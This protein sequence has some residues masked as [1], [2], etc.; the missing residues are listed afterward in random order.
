MRGLWTTTMLL[1]G[2]VAKII[3]VV[4]ARDSVFGTDLGSRHLQQDELGGNLK[5]RVPI[6]G[7]AVHLS[8]VAGNTRILQRPGEIAQSGLRALTQLLDGRCFQLAYSVRLS[9]DL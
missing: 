4:Q 5:Q 6:G 7:V 1:A 9:V 2:P 3:V 8:S